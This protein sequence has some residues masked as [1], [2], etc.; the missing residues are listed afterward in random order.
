MLETVLVIAIGVSMAYGVAALVAV[1]RLTRLRPKR[2]DDFT[3]PV[4]VLKPVKGLDP[5][6]LE[7][8]RSFFRQ[9]Y[10][11]YQILFGV[12]DPKDP[13]VPVIQQVLAEHPEADARLV[14]CPNLLGPNAK[15][16][17]LHQMAAEARHEILIVSDSD[18]RVAP[19][20]LRHVAAPFADPA[21]GLATAFYRGGAPAGLAAHLERLCIHA[22]FVPGALVACLLDGQITFGLGATL[23][24]RRKVLEDL[25]GF[26]AF[27]HVLAEDYLL[28]N[29]AVAAGATVALADT[30]VDCVL[31]RIPFQAFFARQVRWARTNRC[32][33][34]LGY[35]GSFL[36]HGLALS[37]LLLLLSGPTP[38]SLALL[39]A[40]T[41]LQ[42]AVTWV[43]SARVLR[44]PDPARGLWLLPLADILSIA[45]WVLAFAGN[46][47]TWRGLRYR[48]TRGGHLIPLDG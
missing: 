3:P 33:R 14:L 36:R 48:M 45:L 34:P 5:G 46:T 27:T 37:L 7:N 28:A 41:C 20:Y 12:A 30:V 25:G 6:Q 4:T 44:A 11:S 17:K 29:R 39:G 16:S 47:I 15:V 21:V 22:L 1:A 8:F 32:C 42:A 10:P 18:T 26:A 13:A 31:G 43:V 19:D 38:L 23:A 40:S 24:V 9:D 35:L 2:P